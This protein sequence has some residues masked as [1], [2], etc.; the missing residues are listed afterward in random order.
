MSNDIQKADQIAYHLFTKLTL[1][2]NQARA[3]AEST[4][5]NSSGGGSSRPQVKV[6]KWVRVQCLCARYAACGY[7]CMGLYVVLSVQPRDARF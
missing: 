4:S 5:S 1:V 3:T 7:L 2:V 6:D